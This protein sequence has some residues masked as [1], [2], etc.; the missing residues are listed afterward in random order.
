MHITVCTE[1]GSSTNVLPAGANVG[2]TGI[3]CVVVKPMM[4]RELPL[5]R[6][7][8]LPI[9]IPKKPTSGL[10]PLSCSLRVRGL[11]FTG[12]LWDTGSR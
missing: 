2:D 10:E 3:R 8:G 4:S 7:F 11:P 5:F 9:P 12:V 6:V 1:V